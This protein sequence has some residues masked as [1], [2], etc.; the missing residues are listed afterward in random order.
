MESLPRDQIRLDSIFYQIPDELWQHNIFIHL[1]GFE[2]MVLAT[3]SK[4]NMQFIDVAREKIR[5]YI[6]TAKVLPRWGSNTIQWGT[7][8]L[9]VIK[10]GRLF[11]APYRR[12]IKRGMQRKIVHDSAEVCGLFSCT[13]SQGY[14]YMLKNLGYKSGY[15]SATVNIIEDTY[16]MVART[17]CDIP[18]D[19]KL[20]I[21]TP[22]LT[23]PL[24]SEFI[25]AKN[26]GKLKDKASLIVGWY[27]KG[28]K[29]SVPDEIYRI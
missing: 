12:N 22:G 15:C 20:H 23:P 25:F 4:S 28:K 2:L 29:G 18:K 24:H 10:Y 8:M 1:S 11:I 3:T 13:I 6:S 21:H 5:K 19:V 26:K 17:K 14:T 7:E 27:A 16:V 9:D